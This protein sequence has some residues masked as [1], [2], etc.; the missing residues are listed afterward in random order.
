MQRD[1]FVPLLVLVSV[2]IASVCNASSSIELSYC[3]GCM[4]NSLSGGQQFQNPMTIVR[5]RL[6]FFISFD[7]SKQ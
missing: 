4:V 2:C 5:R 6:R 7:Q 1:I 3:I